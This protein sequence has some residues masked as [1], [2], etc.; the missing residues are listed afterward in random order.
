[1][2][3]ISD[4][5]ELLAM[6]GK[7]GSIPDNLMAFFLYLNEVKRI[8]KQEEFK[9]FAMNSKE[10]DSLAEI[11]DEMVAYCHENL[12]FQIAF[13]KWDDSAQLNHW[14]FLEFNFNGS[15]TPTLDILICDP[16]GFVQSLVLTNLLSCGLELGRL[17]KF[18]KLNVYIP[19]DILQNSGRG[20]A[21]F[22]SDSI[23]MLSNQDKFNP[24]YD[25]MSTHQQDQQKKRA[26]NTLLSFREAVA[27]AYTE[28]ELDDIYKFNIVVSSLPTRL[29]RTQQSVETLTKEILELEDRGSELVNKKGATESDSILR[30]SFF[31]KTRNEQQE[32]RNMR[33]NIKMEKLG[34]NVRGVSSEIISEEE[35]PMFNEAVQKHSLS[36]LA[37][38]IEEFTKTEGLIHK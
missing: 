21:Y 10:I 24:L 1:M 30:H 35:V 3:S 4:I 38:F 13:S 33:V 25:Y 6:S 34:E 7:P 26:I 9:A 37:E 31:V 17:S 20:C 12:R 14:S 8:V 5:K 29:I 2:K 16:L 11:I 32:Y 27:V 22:V 18:C 28:E 19:S 15:T 23:S 36:G